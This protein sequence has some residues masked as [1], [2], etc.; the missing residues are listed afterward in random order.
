MRRIRSGNVLLLLLLGTVVHTGCASLE[1]AS[2]SVDRGLHRAGRDVSADLRGADRDSREEDGAGR[3]AVSVDDEKFD[4]T[5]TAGSSLADAD[6]TRRAIDVMVSVLRQC[7]EYVA[8]VHSGKVGVIDIDADDGIIRSVQVVPA[9]AKKCVMTQA[10]GAQIA[11]SGSLVDDVELK[12]E[13]SKS[14]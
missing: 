11:E 6:V 8:H 13:K 14:N 2:S 4:L 3:A 12:L 10:E 5:V 7:D 9:S 1:N